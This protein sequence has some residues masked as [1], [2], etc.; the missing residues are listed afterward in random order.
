MKRPRPRRNPREQLL[1]HWV[2]PTFTAKHSGAT[3]QTWAKVYHADEPGGVPYRVIYVDDLGDGQVE[4]RGFQDKEEALDFAKSVV[5]PWGRH[6]CL[7]GK[8]TA[9][10][11]EARTYGRCAECFKN[12][13][14]VFSGCRC[15]R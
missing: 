15:G 2:G 9:K 13:C 12:G 4:Y 8:P 10:S 1:A 6:R 5:D 14:N 11:G 7:C 3:A